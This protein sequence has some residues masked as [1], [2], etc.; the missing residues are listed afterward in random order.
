[1]VTEPAHHFTCVAVIVGMAAVRRVQA[2]F[3]AFIDGTDVLVHRIDRFEYASVELLELA[4]L[5]RLL[6]AVV[7]HVIVAIGGQETAASRY[8]DAV[9]A[10][11]LAGPCRIVVVGRPAE[12]QLYKITIIFK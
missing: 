6:H 11:Q 1:M 12:R 7:L 8:G 2:Q 10:G 9:H 3:P 5:R 4:Q